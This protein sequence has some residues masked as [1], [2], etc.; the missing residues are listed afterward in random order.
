MNQRPSSASK[1]SR[2]N[3]A[4]VAV[5]TGV[6]VGNGIIPSDAW[7]V[8]TR[9]TKSARSTLGIAITTIAS[10]SSNCWALTRTHN[11]TAVPALLVP[12]ARA[13]STNVPSPAR[14]MSPSAVASS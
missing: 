12:L 13:S 3:G 4:G 2:V 6:C 11:G 5:G 14:W 7:T 8:A 1:A 10:L 9:G